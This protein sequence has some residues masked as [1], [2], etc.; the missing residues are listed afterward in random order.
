MIRW[1]TVVGALVLLTVCASDVAAQEPNPTAEAVRV[2]LD[3]QGCDVTF[4]R[5]SIDWIN[6]V[7]DRD[8]AQVHVFITSRSSAAALEYTVEFLGR[9]E[10]VGQ[11]QVFTLRVSVTDTVDERRR[12]LAR[13]VRMGLARYA[14]QTSA[15]TVLDVQPRA[16]QR[17]GVARPQNDP[18]NF[19]IMSIGTTGAL[20]GEASIHG[21]SVSVSP[22]AN[23]TTEAWKISLRADAR[24]A[25]SSFE[26]EDGT[27][28]ESVTGSTDG[29]FQAIKSL[30][31][32][33]G[34]GVGGHVQRSTFYNLRPS[35]RLAA[36][37]E[38]N[39]FPYGESS[40]RA[41]TFTY[42]TG[43]TWLEYEEETIFRANR[44]ML[45]SQGV[46]L[47]LDLNRPWGSSSIDIQARHFVGKPSQHRL[48]FSATLD[49]RVVRGLGITVFGDYSVVR[50]QRFLP[51]RSASDEEILLRRRALATGFNFVASFGLTYTFG[52]IFNS[53]VNSRLTGASGRFERIF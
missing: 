6:W 51:K 16:Q 3:C 38:Y 19:W 24:H 48:S 41:L 36:A 8:V 46:L 10:F 9:E 4:L 25:E 33:W 1:L 26:F 40:Q 22:S 2:F 45:V 14:V 27:S 5:Q 35:Y 43:P 42:F 20:N 28:F 21:R 31:D 53:T 32:H 23:R 44:E 12:N 18:W 30:G 7:R 39:I 17:R 49:Y 37:L 11:D 52:S 15:G 29:G 47:S 13:T 50:D 34:L